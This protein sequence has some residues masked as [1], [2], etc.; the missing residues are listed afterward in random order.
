MSTAAIPQAVL[1]QSLIEVINGRRVKTAVF[2]T[3][4]FDPGFFEINILPLLFDQ[5]FSQVDKV[6]RLQLED[7]LGAIEHLDVYYDR[8]ALSQDAEP[9]QLPYRR[10]DVRRATGCFHPKL[11]F[12]LVNEFSDDEEDETVQSLIVGVLSANLTRAG[13]WENL[14][15]AHFE[16]IKDVYDDSGRL[17]YRKEL[18]Y[19]IRRIKNTASE[20]EEH[21]GLD[22]V[23][24]FLK[25]RVS[26]DTYSTV[27][28]G[29]GYFTQLFCGQQKLQFADWL[30][31]LHLR[32]HNL[33][34][35]VISPYFDAKG[36][37]PLEAIIDAVQPREVRVY[38]PEEHDGTALVSQ[39]AYQA[40][41]EWAFWSRFDGPITQRGRSET[42]E[43]LTPRR[44][45]A[46]VYRL[47]RKNGPDLLIVGSVNLTSSAHSH[48]GAGNLEAAILV[49]MSQS[50]S[51]K[52]WWLTPLDYESEQFVDIA[53]QEED[54]LDTPFCDL[55][56]RFDWGDAT[57]SY[58]AEG[59]V[60]KKLTLCDITGKALMELTNLKRN[61]WVACSNDAAD[62]FRDYLLSSSFVVVRHG[63]ANWKVLVREEN[64]GH[65]PSILTQLTH[66]EILEYWSLLSPEQ[67]ASFIES[68]LLIGQELQGLPVGRQDLGKMHDSIFDHFAGVYHA[69]GCLKRYVQTAIEEERVQEAETRLFGAKYDSLPSLLEKLVDEA[70]VD[71][72]IR[73]V[74]FL[75]AQQLYSSIKKHY[76]DFI[77]QAKKYASKLESHLKKLPT[78]RANLPLEQ[79]GDRT[80]FLDWFESGF[81]NE[82]SV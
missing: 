7:A 14:E 73:Y 37:G 65:R 32:K 35:E 79:I 12:L 76:P 56:L 80:E 48:G 70:D 77:R 67:R 54:G 1:S 8:S 15:C 66:D 23:H 53:P 64:M 21:P 45:H 74:T 27:S 9:A 44:V 82:V 22:A 57:L 16:E 2:S 49:D 6:R 78:I 69:F 31:S 3:F 72:I 33:N 42:A 20:D 36:T 26:K 47:W 43:K 4:N 81:L 68:R 55:S 38:L 10:I 52:R 30:R 25:T 62:I 50:K 39:D 71:P 18:L 11:V 24:A 61:R 41:G 17:A 19:L 58:R 13:W 34:L 51:P 63:K 40:I 28:S 75:S 46:K 59:N 60:P 29:K 5:S